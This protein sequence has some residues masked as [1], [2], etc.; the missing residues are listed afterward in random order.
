[1][2][3][4]AWRVVVALL[5]LALGAC[6]PAPASSVDAGSSWRFVSPSAMAGFTPFDVVRFGNGFVTV[7]KAPDVGS[8]QQG[9]AYTSTDGSSWTAAPQE[10][11]RSY[12]LSVGHDT[13]HGLLVLGMVCSMECGGFDSWLSTDAVSWSAP[14]KQPFTDSVS[15][16]GLA[17]RGSTIV[18]VGVDL[19]D[20]STNH[21]RSRVF[22]SEDGETWTEAPEADVLDSAGLAGVAADTEGYA[23]V[24]RVLR[25]G[26]GTDGGAWTSA[27]G[28]TWKK[29]KD[30]GSFQG[31]LLQSVVR[32]PQGFV[33]VGAVGADG[34]VWTSVDG[35]AWVRVPDN[36]TFTAKPLV[37]IATNGAG[38]LVIGR[39]AAGGAA[40]TSSDGASWRSAGTI[41]GAE[42]VAFAA[43][44]IGGSGSIIVGRPVGADPSGL[45]WLGPLP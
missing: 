15:P 3:T 18:A 33:A 22:R 43:A 7:G 8:L 28:L 12:T 4:A 11:F 19:V 26:G 9:G 36:G 16:T 31:A 32:G 25:D 42:G 37:E 44:A 34:A 41:P 27:D 38:Y 13:G 17:Q 29:A 39:D 21:I 24:G 2:H 5:M 30:D 23:A 40:W 10:P 1:M 6:G 14:V 45:V 20:V 35:T